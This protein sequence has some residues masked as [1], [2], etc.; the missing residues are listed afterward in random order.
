MNNIKYKKGDTC[1]FII[2]NIEVVEGIIVSTQFGQ[3]IIRYKNN[4]IISLSQYR[5]FPSFDAAYQY[6]ERIRKAQGLGFKRH[7]TPYDY[8]H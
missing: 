1:Y 6:M 4:A 5:L 8:D 3:Y 2:S 7:K